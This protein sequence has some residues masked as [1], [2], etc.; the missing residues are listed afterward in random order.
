M[1]PTA[2]SRVIILQGPLLKTEAQRP[3]SHSPPRSFPLDGA[4]FSVHVHS[5]FTPRG[6]RLPVHGSG[7]GGRG[8]GT[9]PSRSTRDTHL[10]GKSLPGHSRNS[11]RTEESQRAQPW[12]RDRPGADLHCCGGGAG[13]QVDIRHPFEAPV[14]KRK[15]IPAARTQH[16]P[17]EP[18]EARVCHRVR[19]PGPLLKSS[20]GPQTLPTPLIHEVQGLWQ[21]SGSWLPLNREKKVVVGWGREM[22][23]R[24]WKP[25]SSCLTL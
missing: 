1:P 15:L 16:R 20:M 10:P 13:T 6:S 17:T 18:R 7:R 25:T 2:R 3:P 12:R 24:T 11:R 9:C 23:P 5:G 21:K 14:E 8:R 22:K 19:H 4:A